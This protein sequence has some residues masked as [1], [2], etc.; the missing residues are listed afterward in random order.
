MQTKSNI[1]QIKTQTPKEHLTQTMLEHE[2]RERLTRIDKEMSD[3]FNIINKYNH[4]VTV[5]GS[6][7]FKPGHK[8]YDLARETS[9]KI[10]EAGFSV[11]TG[12]GGGIMEAGNRGAFEAGGQ[13]LGFNIQLPFEQVLNPYT[14]E[15]MP[16]RYFFSR[17]VILAFGA[18]AYVFFPGGFGTLDE[19]FEIITLI[20]TKKAPAVPIVLV[21]SEFWNGLDSYIKQCMLAQLDTIS[22]GDEQLYTITDDPNEV[23]DLIKTN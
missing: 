1:T 11:A 2:T 5:F 18:E 21:G 23:I 16:F 15:A 10:A 22:E 9:R 8:Y 14:T 3:G 12:G 7:R 13:S 19:F 6:A 4:T 17:K 20:Q